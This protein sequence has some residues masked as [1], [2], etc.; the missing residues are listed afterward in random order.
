MFWLVKYCRITIIIG[1]ILISFL[2]VF[3]S[4]SIPFFDII[5][6][7]E[8][9]PIISL[10]SQDSFNSLTSK[11][12]IWPSL[13]EILNNPH[14]GYNLRDALTCLLSFKNLNSAKNIF[15]Y[16]YGWSFQ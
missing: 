10:L 1:K 6:V 7:K 14:S 12:I 16:F 3:S 8:K 5:N 13:E 9:E 2:Q 4:T 11:E 15:I